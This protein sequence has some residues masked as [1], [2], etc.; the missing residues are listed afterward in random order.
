AE[1]A[2]A[3]CPG[4]CVTPRGP[5]R[6]VMNR[7]FTDPRAVGR[8]EPGTAPGTADASGHADTRRRSPAPDALTRSFAG[9]PDTEDVIEPRDGGAR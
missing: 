6:S 1:R 8:Q 4:G 5:A 3:A 9:S 2:A 7:A